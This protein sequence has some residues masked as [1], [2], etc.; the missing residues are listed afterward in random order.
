MATVTDKRKVLRVKGKVK[1]IREIENGGKGGVGVGGPKLTF[2][3]N[4]V[5]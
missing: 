2:V 3:G 5:S 1:V 4:L